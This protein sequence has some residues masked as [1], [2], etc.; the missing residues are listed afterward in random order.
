MATLQY[1]FEAIDRRQSRVRGGSGRNALRPRHNAIELKKLLVDAS[2][3]V[4]SLPA[5]VRLAEDKNTT[6][7]FVDTLER[8]VNEIKNTT[9]HSGAFLQKVKKSE[10]P[11][12][13]DVIKKPMDLATLMKRVKSQMYRTKQSFADD[14]N[15]IWDNAFLYNTHPDHPLRKSADFLRQKS[16]QLLEFISDPSLPA[17]SIYA[18][19]ARESASRGGINGTPAPGE[20]VEGEGLGLRR[21]STVGV[22]E[23]GEDEDRKRV[24]EVLNRKLLNGVGAEGRD[25]SDSPMISRST[26]PHAGDRHG[27]TRSRSP[28]PELAF[29]EH[30]AIIRTAQGMH[31]L[32]ALDRE[33]TSL[34]RMLSREGKREDPVAST[35]RLGL[36]PLPPPPPVI[37]T[38][39]SS[40]AL[41]PAPT[42][43]GSAHPSPSPRPAT[44]ISLPATSVLPLAATP[45]T[46]LAHLIK[47]F[48]PT[49]ASTAPP[50]PADSPAPPPGT[51][52]QASVSTPTPVVNGKSGGKEGGKEK[53]VEGEEEKL[54]EA[55]WWETVTR[56]RALAAGVPC[57]PFRS[58]NEAERKGRKKGKGKKVAVGE[59]AVEVNGKG[60]KEVATAAGKTNGRKGGRKA[61]V[62]KGGKE[63]EK[64]AN[65]DGEG[66]PEVK[67]ERGL[68][69]RMSINIETLKEI[70]KLHYQ[71]ANGGMSSEG[72]LDPSLAPMSDDEVEVDETSVAST[73]SAPRGPPA[74]A[75]TGIP[76]SA[77]QSHL[78][79]QAGRDSL[80]IVSNKI[81][82][83]AGFDATSA[84]AVGVLAHVAAEY[85]MNLGKT[86]RFYSDR[87]GSQ[88]STEQIL[89]HTLNENGVPAP[90]H[91]ESYV[92]EDIDHYGSKLKD[93]RAKLQ[94]ARQ[95]QLD[96]F[97]GPA[98][99]DEQIFDDENE[100]FVLGQYNRQLGEDFFGLGD[101]GLEKELG[102]SVYS[103]PLSLL[104]RDPSD[105]A[106]RPLSSGVKY[107]AP[108]PHIPLTPA[109][110]DC[111][112]GLLRP[113]YLLR[114]KT[115]A[116][117]LDDSALP[118]Q[119]AV[120]RNKILPS[121]RIPVKIKRKADE[122]QPSKSKKKKV[123]EL[124]SE[125]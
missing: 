79:P 122:A 17:R 63:K 66:V 56:E 116:G 57:C 60:K 51:G 110:I 94:K 49:P 53:E 12:Y 46:R 19:V 119:A 68:G 28:T 10:V 93:L 26:T 80:A 3:G 59:D 111:Q 108:P 95:V 114:Q 50:T 112:I 104:K 7:D 106:A 91:I 48:A 72:T 23:D 67:E 117:M 98:V 1:L 65:K 71:L 82:G 39:S 74:F 87:Y 109:A 25:G 13:Y 64:V 101:L 84:T 45:Q 18:Q 40:S 105:P 6:H 41:A 121:G 44:P 90:S 58:G 35:S 123:V 15:L 73:S 55:V 100:A 36:L 21:G 107:P 102:P 16:N 75:E 20:E 85:I 88:M 103:I 99:E 14:L 83:H 9:E 27:A 97:D 76:A 47:T 78:A 61:M 124:E 52:S 33:L 70:R 29:E 92:T 113:I 4:V 96:A 81:L 54:T 125:V 11:D 69:A 118:D 62:K 32:D 86:L 31:D 37:D 8:I 22:G 120:L 34:E 115:E 30:A 43:N 24:L 38:S 89:L 77:F 5:R 42:T 2:E